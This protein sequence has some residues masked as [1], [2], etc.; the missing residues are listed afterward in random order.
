VT[1]DQLLAHLAAD[2]PATAVPAWPV[3]AAWHAHAADHAARGRDCEHVH[4][5]EVFAS[6][7]HTGPVH[8]GVIPS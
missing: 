1:Y 8:K 2:H 5:R 6:Y 3:S 7:A 4:Q